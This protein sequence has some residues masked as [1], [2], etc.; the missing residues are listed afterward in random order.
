MTHPDD[1]PWHEF[2]RACAVGKGWAERPRL[3]RRPAGI[4]D[5]SDARD[6]IATWAKRDAPGD[7]QLATDGGDPDSALAALHDRMA[8]LL[9]I[10]A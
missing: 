8:S 10:V 2:V 4:M 9:G 1:M 5:T 3:K 7:V 6:W